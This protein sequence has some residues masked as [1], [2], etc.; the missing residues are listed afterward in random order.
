MATVRGALQE[1]PLPGSDA[2]M[3]TG[4]QE[5]AL[6]S[7]LSGLDGETLLSPGFL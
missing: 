5:T 1:G 2:G 3:M 4:S 6:T 7:T